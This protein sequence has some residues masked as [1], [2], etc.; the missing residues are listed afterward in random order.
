MVLLNRIIDCWRLVVA[1]HDYV[2]CDKCGCKVFYDGKHVAREYMIW[3][4]GRDYRFLCP[5]CIADIEQRLENQ[6]SVTDKG[7]EE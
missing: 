6:T 2:S 7:P 5:D 1:F 3:R 4:F